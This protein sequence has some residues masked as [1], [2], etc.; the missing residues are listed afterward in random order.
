MAS[1]DADACREFFEHDW[2]SNLDDEQRVAAEAAADIIIDP[3]APETTCPACLTTFPTGPSDC[4]E[5]GLCIG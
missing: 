2:K 5:C 1:S 3:S 4:P